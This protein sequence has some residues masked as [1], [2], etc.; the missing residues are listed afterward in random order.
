MPGFIMQIAEVTVEGWRLRRLV[1]RAG[2][3]ATV[4]VRA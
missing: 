2:R 3:G 1:A 4:R